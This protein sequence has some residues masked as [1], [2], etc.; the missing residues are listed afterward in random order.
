MAED[1]NQDFSGMQQSVLIGTYIIGEVI[2]SNDEYVSY[3]G[4]NLKTGKTVFILES[5]HLEPEATLPDVSTKI[6]EA[7]DKAHR[8]T[9][10]S[11]EAAFFD[12][13]ILYVILKPETRLQ[14]D[15]GKQQENKESKSVVQE[16]VR[17]DKQGRNT[18]SKPRTK[19]VLPV[20]IAAVC[21]VILIIIGNSVGSNKG[22]KNKKNVGIGDCI[23]FGTY[24]QDNDTSNGKE[25]IEWLVLDKE[26]DRIL[27]ISKYSLDS[28]KYNEVGESATWKTCSLRNWL[29][30]NFMDSAFSS[31]EKSQIMTSTVT[32][33]KNPNY[34]TS[35]GNNTEDKVFL[36][37]IPEVNQYFDS[38][39]ARRCAPTDYAIAQGASVDNYY[40][41]TNG[42]A[43]CPWWLRSPGSSS[44]NAAIVLDG[45]SVV[46]GG[47]RGSNETCGVR[48][49][50][51]ISL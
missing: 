12:D 31:D 17:L 43:T 15:E 3:N 37:S 2:D 47:H 36:L 29:N 28:Q 32:A 49:A 39:E 33:D 41:T 24:E 20:I 5:P 48:P 1:N 7:F 45:G 30:A 27:V 23:T 44:R 14:K 19:A 42:E 51:W 11:R 38:D 46:Y 9:S 50:L 8:D 16:D 4:F 34:D 22:I 6:T 18:D 13:D 21:V 35:P 26:D 10:Y 40:F 25:D